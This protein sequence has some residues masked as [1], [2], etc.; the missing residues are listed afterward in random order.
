[1]RA[2]LTTPTFMPFA[3]GLLEQRPQ[4]LA[5]AVAVEVGVFGGL[6]QPEH[7]AVRVLPG[8]HRGHRRRAVRRD[9]VC[10]VGAR[11]SR[12]GKLVHDQL[13]GHADGIH[14]RGRD[15]RHA[16]AIADEQDYILRFSTAL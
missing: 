6:V 1:M 3:L 2:V 16:H 11:Q 7:A 13:A 5:V 4:R 15:R 12:I 14:A 8:H 10:G 9:R